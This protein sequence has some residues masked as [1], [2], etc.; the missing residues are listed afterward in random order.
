MEI[1]TR[2]KSKSI[3]DKKKETKRA[4]AEGKAMDEIYDEL[5]SSAGVIRLYR[6]ARAWDRASKYFTHTTQL[7]DK[8][9]LILMTEENIG[10]R[11]YHHY[12]T[13]LH[14]KNQKIDWR[15]GTMCRNVTRGIELLELLRRMES[16][17]V[18]G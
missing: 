12:K 16:G 3:K 14:Q 4:V 17:C 2:Q 6:I 10:K 9:R 1:G 7:K 15:R 11:C 8:D 13:L 18:T 5:N